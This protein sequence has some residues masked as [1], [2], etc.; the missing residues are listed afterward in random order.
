METEFSPDRTRKDGL[1]HYC[2]Q[3]VGINSKKYYQLNKEIRNE[4]GKKYYIDN[5]EKIIRNNSKYLLNKR[6]SNISCK[7]LDNLRRRVNHAINDNY[8]S[9]HTIELLGCSIKQLKNHLENK[10]AVGMSWDNYGRDGWHI[11][12]I[13]PCASFDLSKPEEQKKCFH[14]TNLQPLWAKDNRIKN[15]YQGV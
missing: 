6:K 14:Y 13:K 15:K 11:D 7:I 8:K 12:H 10:F 9:K 3:C 1:H 4:Y 5:K 2:K